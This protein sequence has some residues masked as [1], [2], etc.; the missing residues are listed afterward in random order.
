MDHVNFSVERGEIHAIV[1]E[2]GSGKSTLARVATRL[3]VPTN[4]R[5][6][7]NGEDVTFLRSRAEL[8]DY[9]RRVQM[10]FQDPFSSINPSQTI[11]DH[12]AEPLIVNGMNGRAQSL[13]EKVQRT[14][15]SA[16]LRPAEIFAPRY[17]KE[18][19]GGQRQRAVIAGALVMEPELVI[20]DEPVSML[21]VSV[22]AEIIKLM[23]QLRA[24]RGLAYIFIMHDFHLAAAIA[25]RVSVMRGGRII[26]AGLPGDVLKRP[27]EDYTRQLLASAPTLD[28]ALGRRAARVSNAS[29][30]SRPMP[31]Q[32]IC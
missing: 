2:S 13:A 23:L 5:M 16:G 9:R 32:G 18:L 15:A 6:L 1:G 19:S 31:S 26:E 28:E 11:F 20:A 3:Q 25:D 30:L 4:G 10:I 12:V 29:G 21:D 17:P 27:S 7:M 14:L 22:S 24:S 8:R